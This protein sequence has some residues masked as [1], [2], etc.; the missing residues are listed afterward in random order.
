MRT[1]TVKKL[2]IAAGLLVVAA[3][4]LQTGTST[5][6][7][8]SS[9]LM[10]PELKSQLNQLHSLTV[11]QGDNT[12]TIE[13]AD[14]RWVVVEK[15]NYP[16]DAVKLRGAL[17]DLA[18]ARRLEAKTANPKR[19]EQ[20]GLAS[21]GEGTTIELKGASG[22]AFTPVSL[23]AG[24][25]VQADYRYVRMTDDNQ[26]W[27][28]DRDPDIPAAATEWLDDNLIDIRSI[29]IHAVRIEHADGE[30]LSFTRTDGTL[31]PDNLPEGRELTS[32]SATNSIGNA[33]QALRLDDVQP[34]PADIEA[35]TTT[36][37]TSTTGLAVTAR[38]YLLDDEDWFAF[39]ASVVEPA[40][41]EEATDSD[42][43]EASADDDEQASANER[44]TAAALAAEINERAQGWLYRLPSYKGEAFVKR[45]ADLLKSDDDA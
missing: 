40:T 3:I 2:A 38:H 44:A 7:G 37:L 18:E 14:E 25:P 45:W 9:A 4:I 36:I 27:L 15:S 26:S 33:L 43:D 17:L 19:H 42:G 6:N 35:D 20:L 28:I 32:P 34:A 1:A 29:D 39:A 21:D 23:L 8:S 10:L 12:V 31:A 30:Q 5:T 24:N 41:S 16:A 13:R 11:R 22:E